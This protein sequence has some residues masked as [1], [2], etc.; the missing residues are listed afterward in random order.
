MNK[1]LKHIYIVEDEPDI[2]E[3]ISYKFDTGRL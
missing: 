2:R 1:S 3:T